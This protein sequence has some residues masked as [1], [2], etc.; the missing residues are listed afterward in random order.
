MAALAI[1]V[2]ASAYK[3]A[4]VT[5]PTTFTVDTT[6]NASLAMAAGTSPDAGVTVTV[7]GRRLTITINDTMQP[8][9][10]YTF[11]DVFRITNTGP[12]GGGPYASVSLSYAA[13]DGWPA[14]VT[15]ALLQTGTSNDLGTVILNNTTMTSV[16]ADIRITV[17][18]GYAGS[19]GTF[20]ISVTG[21]R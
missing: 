7:S 15:L 18:A 1:L 11:S 17:D 13:T 3:T 20:G 21:S 19:G 10:V 2:S 6:G 12:V 9:S 5:N 4:I 16:E 14:G 8:G